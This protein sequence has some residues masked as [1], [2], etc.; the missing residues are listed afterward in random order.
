MTTSRPSTSKDAGP[1]R[2]PFA[3]AEALLWGPE[4][5]KQHAYLLTEMRALQKQHEGY[6]TR[7][8]TT[9]AVADAAEAATVRIRHLEQK[10]AAIEAEDDDK[11]FEKWAAG[12]LAR[13]DAFVDANKD[14][15]QKMIEL[16]TVVLRV[17]EDV[18]GLKGVE[19]GIEGVMRRLEVLERGRRE[20]AKKIQRLEGEILRF[21]EKEAEMNSKKSDKKERLVFDDERRLVGDYSIL[22]STQSMTRRVEP[23]HALN[24]DHPNRRTKTPPQTLD[25]DTSDS[26]TEPDDELMILPKPGPQVIPGNVQVPQSPAIHE[27]KDLLS[28]A[29]R[30]LLQRPSI[31]E[32]KLPRLVEEEIPHE[33][34]V[35][36]RR[37]F[38]RNSPAETQ[39]VDR[40]LQAMAPLAQEIHALP[41]SEPPATQIVNRAISKKRKQPDSAPPTQRQTRS[42]AKKSRDMEVEDE[43]E[44]A[45]ET[46]IQPTQFVGPKTL[47]RKKIKTDA[48]P[49]ITSSKARPGRATQGATKPRGRPKKETVD[50]DSNEKK[51]VGSTQ[52]V[53]ARPRKSRAKAA[54]SPTKK[55][56][57]IPAAQ[58][59]VSPPEQRRLMVTL[60]SPRKMAASGLDDSENT[61]ISAAD[62][63]KISPRK[64]ATTS[65]FKVTPKPLSTRSKIVQAS[66][67]AERGGH[68]G[69]LIPDEE[70]ELLFT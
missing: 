40:S 54:I 12:E 65:P 24:D 13:L 70:D 9:E 38:P 35:Q 27:K 14:F 47:P 69:G 17:T 68:D 25:A 2:M 41:T 32:S 23:N 26:T 67:S 61:Q 7:I 20:D 53:T 57:P 66:P 21:G 8:Q 44:Q 52:P 37:S 55:T 30:R 45:S 28:S 15:R 29:R 49:A 4:M 11:V 31:H 63:V 50:V 58:R 48:A 1:P 51:P 64:A 18:D 60:P 43:Q 5:K 36:D 59:A 33:S 46:L 62:R 34:P 3:S 10:L 16:G 56:A 42:Q 39:I 22:E 19:V 6:N